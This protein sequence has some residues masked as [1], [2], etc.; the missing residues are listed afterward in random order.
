MT[1]QQWMTVLVTILGGCGVEQDAAETPIVEE[2]AAYAPMA[3]ARLNSV[4]GI[5]TQMNSA[6]G[7]PGATTVSSP[8]AGVYDVTFN[9]F[10]AAAGDASGG[11]IQVTA[12]GTNN[13]RCRVINWSGTT[14]ITA[15]VRCNTPTGTLADTPLAILFHRS[16][17]PAP[18][19]FGVSA[20]YAFVGSTGLVSSTWDY[21]SSG[22]HNTATKLGTGSYRVNITNATAINAS[23][24]VT[25]HGNDAV[26]A[27]T[28]WSSGM[29]NVAC[30]NAAGTAVDSAFSFSYATTGPTREQQGGH[31]WFSASTGAVH[32]TYTSALGKVSWCSPAAV[33]SSLSGS[34]AQISVV[35][36]LG[37]WSA[38]P[39]LRANFV[40]GYGT[41]KYCKVESQ[42]A[43]GPALPSTGTANVRCYAPSGTVVPTPTFTFTHVTSDVTGP[44]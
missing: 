10:P 37:S 23:M 2:R 7:A 44:C 3:F 36:D 35:G 39:F 34:L 33:T 40:S 30:A 12:E 42:S 41:A 14:S 32:P 22:V 9:G 16:V 6:S 20:A 28:N 24:M 1:K 21:N 43:T 13:V 17:M 4:G 25:T 31:A 19:A 15:Q 29:A 18:N 27:I 26:C 11:N 5:V 8:S 38:D